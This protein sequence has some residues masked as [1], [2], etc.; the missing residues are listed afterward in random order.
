MILA[1]TRIRREQS[2]FIRSVGIT[3]PSG[4]LNMF[5]WMSKH[6]KEYYGL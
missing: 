6:M 4:K 5:V 3:T 1:G 2:L